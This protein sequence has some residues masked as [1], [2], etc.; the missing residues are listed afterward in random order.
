MKHKQCL[1]YGN[2]LMGIGLLV[3][4]TG[5]V[6]AVMSQLHSVHLPAVA[7]DGAVFAIFL[8]ALLWLA[9]AQLGGREKV[10]DRYF[11]LRYSGC[12]LHPRH[13]SSPATDVDSVTQ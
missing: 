12:N 1:R 3:I 11:L 7:V 10:C 9:G 5:M 4:V 13:K 8:G 2:A 6:L